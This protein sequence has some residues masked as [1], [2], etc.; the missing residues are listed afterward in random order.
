MLIVKSTVVIYLVFEVAA[1]AQ[2]GNILEVLFVEI[3]GQRNITP[4][5]RWFVLNQNGEVQGGNG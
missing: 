3:A 4:T 5:A 2:M 1:I